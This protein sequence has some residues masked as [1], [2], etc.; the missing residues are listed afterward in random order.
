MN[1]N[2]TNFYLKSFHLSDMLEVYA[3]WK[4]LS[5]LVF[6]FWSTM[7]IHS[8]TIKKKKEKKLMFLDYDRIKYKVR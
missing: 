6:I 8:P 1:S 7:I 2:L 3:L 4:R 5:G